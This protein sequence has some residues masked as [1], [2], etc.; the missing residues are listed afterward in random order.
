MAG[1]GGGL[2]PASLRRASPHSFTRLSPRSSWTSSW[3][4]TGPPTWLTTGRPPPSTCG[5]TPARPSRSWRSK[6]GSCRRGERS[7]AGAALP[8]AAGPGRGSSQ[9]LPGLPLQGRDT[10]SFGRAETDASV[11]GGL[12]GREGGQGEQGT[13][14]AARY[15]PACKNRIKTRCGLNMLS[16]NVFSPLL[17]AMKMSFAEFTEGM[18]HLYCYKILFL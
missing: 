4:G 14:P 2:R 12:A 15:Q 5:S 10:L 16:N 11:S 8:G 6:C 13:L 18:Y 7:G 3:C 9:R 1:L 17:P